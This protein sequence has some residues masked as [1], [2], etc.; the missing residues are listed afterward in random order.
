MYDKKIFS[1]DSISS[2]PT[3]SNLLDRRMTRNFS[4]EPIE[5]EKIE[6][7]LECARRSPSGINH[8]PWQVHVISNAEIKENLANCTKYQNQVKSAKLVFLIYNIPSDYNKVKNYQSIGAFFENIMLACHALGLGAVW[9]GEILN[10]EAEVR[11]ILPPNPPAEDLM[12]LIALGYPKNMTEFKEPPITERK[13]ISDF[14]Y[15]YK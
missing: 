8:Q 5:N 4:T 13:K 7:I 11:R 14:V 9:N 10:N 3:I 2:N 15:W 6:I 12:G 1:D